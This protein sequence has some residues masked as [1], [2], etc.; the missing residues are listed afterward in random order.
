MH[1]TTA[2]KLQP[3]YSRTRPISTSRTKRRCYLKTFSS[4]PCKFAATSY[5][6]AIPTE[7]VPAAADVS[8]RRN[9]TTFRPLGDR[10]RCKSHSREQG[11]HHPYAPRHP[12][13]PIESL[14]CHTLPCS[15]P[16]T[17]VNHVPSCHPALKLTLNP[18][19]GQGRCKRAPREAVCCHRP[20][21]IPGVHIHST[22]KKMTSIL[23][24]YTFRISPHPTLIL[25]LEI[26]IPS[27]QQGTP[28]DTY[29]PLPGFQYGRMRAT[30]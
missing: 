3:P 5:P 16:L 17:G 22:P 11:H 1:A 6:S 9:V 28:S 29:Y 21:R 8:N 7:S 12:G 13:S 15:R 23:S 26:T 2:R 4:P 30:R 19:Q 18:K 10:F 25:H 20:C 14:I 27:P 24:P